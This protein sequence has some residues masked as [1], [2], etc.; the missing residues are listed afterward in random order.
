MSMT[1][2]QRTSDS[3]YIESVTHGWTQ[4]EGSSVRP[5]ECHW[6]MVFVR[7]HGRLHPI[8][9][10]PLQTA[11]LASWGSGAEILW[12]KFK[13]GTFMPHLPVKN[14]IDSE[15]VLPGA[16]SSDSFWLNSSA[17][18]FPTYENIEIFINRLVREDTLRFDPVVAAAL[19]DQPQDVPSRTMRHRFLRTTGLTQGHIRQI[20]R[21]QRAAVLLR[22]GLSIL[23]TVYEMGYCDQ[24]HLTKSLKQFVG[25]TPAQITRPSQVARL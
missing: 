6:H 11:G 9:V 22:D 16:A 2:E 25:Y 23:D 3:P 18:R 17:W 7:E 21:A 24:P 19:Q 5:A 15:T 13:L 1:F 4:S 14:H 8:V 10:G 12:V 20:E